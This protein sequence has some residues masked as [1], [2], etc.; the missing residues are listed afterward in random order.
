MQSV[1]LVQRIERRPPK[2]LI[3]VRFPC[4]TF[5]AVAELADA[6]DLG[7]GVFRRVGSN[8]ISGTNHSFSWVA[9]AEQ[10]AIRSKAD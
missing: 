5:V 10:S 4:T 2:A 1:V 8:P 9:V 7:S 3:R 6:P